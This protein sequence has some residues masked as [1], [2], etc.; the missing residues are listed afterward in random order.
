MKF[1]LASGSPRRLELLRQ[2]GIEPEVVIPHD[3]ENGQKSWA[4]PEEMVESLSSEKAEQIYLK[5]Q[6]SDFIFGADTLVVL[7]NE[8]LEKPKNREDAIEMLKKLSGR[9]HLVLTGVTLIFEGIS[10]TECEVTKVFFRPLKEEE[11]IQYVDSGE[12][13]DKAGAY[14]IQGKAAVF[15]D[16]IE[17]CYFN[18]VGLPLA[19]LWKMMEKSRQ[20]K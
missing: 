5:T 14:G 15:I 9:T 7:E 16:R 2:I 4:N 8:V 1:C 13:M 19:K 11:I 17:G 3:V 12:S 6:A 20:S 10:H 18:V